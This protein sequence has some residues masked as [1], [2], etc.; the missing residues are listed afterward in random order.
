MKFTQEKS[1][2]IVKKPVQANFEFLLM[3]EDFQSQN[4]SKFVNFLNNQENEVINTELLLD[5]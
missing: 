2:Q 5:L 3:L 1:H 4:C